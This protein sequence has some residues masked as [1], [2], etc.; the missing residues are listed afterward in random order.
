[1]EHFILLCLAALVAVPFILTMAPKVA[2][3]FDENSDSSFS[4]YFEDTSPPDHSPR[5]E[6][7]SD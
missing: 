1:M 6:I 5:Q 2:S 4:S 7:M 3:P